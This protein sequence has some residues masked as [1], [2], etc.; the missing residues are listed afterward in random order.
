[1]SNIIKD[2]IKNNN[3]VNNNPSPLR[4][5]MKRN[6]VS[7]QY[8]SL[9]APIAVPT[10]DEVGKSM[11]DENI[12]FSELQN[13]NEIRSQRQPWIAKASAG[14]ARIGTKAL[15]EIAKMPGVILGMGAGAVGEALDADGNEFMKTA[16]NNGWVKAMNNLNQDVNDE[17][18]P[19]YVSKAVKDGNIWDA[20]TSI[21]F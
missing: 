6:N 17:L 13:L 10:G 21:D 11:F 8:D 16:F 1:M 9:F 15:T 4:N 2:Y 18:L 19:V 14:I 3:P 20:I 5:Y 7:T 12:P